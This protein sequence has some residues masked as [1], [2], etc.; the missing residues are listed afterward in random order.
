MIFKTELGQRLV[1]QD[2][3]VKQLSDVNAQLKTQVDEL[4]K[5]NLFCFQIICV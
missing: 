3:A 5:L 1:K 2:A 4:L